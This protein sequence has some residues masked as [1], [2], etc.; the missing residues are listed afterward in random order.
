LEPVQ[1]LGSPLYLL[2]LRFEH[3]GQKRYLFSAIDAK[4]F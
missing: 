2:I 4:L 1:K 3:P